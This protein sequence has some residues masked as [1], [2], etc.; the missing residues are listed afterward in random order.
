M[1][2]AFD[3]SANERTCEFGY[4]TRQGTSSD[5]TLIAIDSDA[6]A[7]IEREVRTALDTILQSTMPRQFDPAEKYSGREYLILPLDHE[8]A[9]TIA[10]F[11]RTNNLADERLQVERLK[12]AYCYFY[13]G[14]DSEGRR[15]TALNR[16]SQLKKPLGQ[17]A[18]YLRWFD[19]S[20]RKVEQPLLQLNTSFDIVVDSIN[21]HILRPASFRA[22]ANVD[23]AVAEAVPRNV[24]AIAEAVPYVDWSNVEEYSKSHPRAASYLASIVT[25]G[26]AENIDP[27]VLQY[28]CNVQDIALNEDEE[29]RLSIDDRNV[30]AFLEVID[31]RRYEIGLVPEALE[32]YKASSRT[33]VG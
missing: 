30:M 17:Q 25:Y 11:H 20:L 7:A 22:L 32:H 26:Y 28:M 27:A 33:R 21:V 14:T 5:F 1:K 15:L 8:L 13:R 4:G 2:V 24:G 12:A 6:Q 3:I 19:D 16:S 10:E 9:R 23:D 29:G 31:R 18:R